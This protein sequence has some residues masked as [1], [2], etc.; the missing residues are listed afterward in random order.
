MKIS[1]ILTVPW[2]NQPYLPFRKSEGENDVDKHV[3]KSKKKN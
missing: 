2:K 1:H 3:K